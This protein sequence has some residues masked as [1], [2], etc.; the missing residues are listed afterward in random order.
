M[1]TDSSCPVLSRWMDEDDDGNDGDE[2]GDDDNNVGGVDDCDSAANDFRNYFL[3]D[4]SMSPT[5]KKS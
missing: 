1:Q 4:T 2:D 5:P 3:L